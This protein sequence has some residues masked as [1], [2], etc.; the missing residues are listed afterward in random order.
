MIQNYNN[1]KFFLTNEEKEDIV[2][3]VAINNFLTINYL[4]KIG[5]RRC[6]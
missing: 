1:R 3:G 6:A 4:F 2:G 5:D